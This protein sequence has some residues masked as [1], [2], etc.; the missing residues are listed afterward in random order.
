MPLTLFRVRKSG[1]AMFNIAA[2][3]NNR[4]NV[5]DAG[6]TNREITNS[7]D[8][9]PPTGEVP[10]VSLSGTVTIPWWY[11]TQV[12]PVPIVAVPV[13]TITLPAAPISVD[14]GD[15][16]TLA[17]SCTLNGIP[18]SPANISWSS[19]KDG[20]LYI[21][22]STTI[23]NLSVNTHVITASFTNGTTATDSETV[24]V[25]NPVPASAPTVTILSPETG[26][27]YPV[28]SA[29]KFNATAVDTVDGPLSDRIKWYS[30]T[31]TGVLYEG[32]TFVL[33]GLPPGTHTI[34]ATCRDL[35]SPPNEGEDS[36]TL[37]IASDA[38]DVT[39]LPLE[40]QVV[41]GRQAYGS[42]VVQ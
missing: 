9:A 36:V 8:A 26:T 15:A 14:T 10:V 5:R 17:A 21:G 3:V 27:S 2:N 18:A 7:P 38:P 31:T 35:D 33:S 16:V 11:V 34:R 40:G 25:N 39:E 24:T 29:V 22:E 37:Y 42:G 19:D 32:Q 23:T 4:L 30:N 1:G 12:E 6:G 28:G 41:I 20:L 13:V